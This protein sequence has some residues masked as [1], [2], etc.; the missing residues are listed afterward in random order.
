MQHSGESIGAIASALAKAQSELTNPEKSLVA[1][2]RSPFPRESD[3]TFRYAS[4]SS[5]LDIVRKALGKHEIATV[6]TTSIDKDA[7]LIRLTTVLAHSSGEWV[8]SDWP[9]CPVGETAAPRRM[10]AALTYARRYALFTLVGIAG[11]DDLD[12]PELP[13]TITEDGSPSTSHLRKTNG[14][15]FD[16]AIA[17][18]SGTKNGSRRNLRPSQPILDA[19]ASGTTRERL[20]NEIAA[21]DAVETAIEWACPN[22]GAKN[23]LTAEDASIVEA[24]FRGRMRVLEPEVY[25]E[26]P[27]PPEAPPVS[28][29]AMPQPGTAGPANSPVAAGTRAL[30]NDPP[31]SR[32]LPGSRVRIQGGNNL[33]LKPRRSRD[34]DHLRFLAAQPCILCGRKPCEAHHLRYAQ[35]RALGR[36]VSDEFTVPLCRVHHRELHRQGDERSW[37]NKANIDPMPIAL[38]FWQHTRGIFPTPSGNHEPQD[39]KTEGSIEK[40]SGPGAHSDGSEPS[41]PV[42]AFK[43][44]PR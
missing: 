1:T 11:E 5:G 32:K 14:Q 17:L 44:A 29:E 40:P 2:I 38:R 24:A 10:G 20:V 25:L 41:L 19:D 21:L 16:N 28:A 35:P 33:T 36:R 43:A 26:N 7:G 8:S 12:A 42:E 39:P 23:T 4:L 27:T 6:Q 30:A 31:R 13:V 22:L 15:T 9:V 34:K 3:R 18:I 37:W